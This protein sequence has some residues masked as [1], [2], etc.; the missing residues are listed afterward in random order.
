MS[1]APTR[2][3]AP[4]RPRR[5]SA[6]PAWLI[7]A[8]LL[9]VFL[10]LTFLL[11]VFPLKDVDF[12]WHLKTGDLIRQTG[13]IP[14]QDIYTY[15]VADHAW[16]DL[17]WGFQVLLSWGYQHAGVVGLNLAKCAINCAAI[18]LLLSARRRDWP[19]GAMLVAWLPALVLLG[20]RM[21][22]RPETLTLLYLAAFLAVLERWDRSAR[23]AF[24][25]PVVQVLWVNTQ[26]LFVLGPIVLSFALVDASLRPGAFG[27]ARRPWWRTVGTASTL[28][29][30]ACLVNPYGIVGALFPIQLAGTMADPIFREHIAELTPIPEF[31]R[32]TA[33]RGS[34]MLWLH[35]AVM[36]LGALSFLVPWVWRVWVRLAPSGPKH[37]GGRG[38]GPAPGK[39]KDKGKSRKASKDAARRKE[40]TWSPSPFRL[41]L[42]LAFSALS[43]QATRNSHQFAAVVGAV[44][45]WNVGEWAAVVRRRRA[46]RPEAEQA[47]V[48]RVW[49]L[50]AIVL[51]LAG[52]ASGGVYALAGE[53]RT[54]GLGEEPLWYP[55][56]AVR[57]AGKPGMPY[58]FLSF[59]DGHSAL[60]IYH[61]GPGHKVFGDPR[62]EVMGSEHFGRYIDLQRRI[63]S[64]RPG[65]QGDLAALGHPAV[66]VD[67]VHTEFSPIGAVMMAAPHWRCAWF[68]AMAA[69]FVH[70]E[71]T[72]TAVAPGVDFAAR[73]F[74]PEP[75]TDPRD[76]PMLMASAKALLNYAV[77]LQGQ[78][79][80]DL[81]RR[82]VPLGIDYARR[83]LRV[84]PGAAEG[85]KILGRLEATRD[86]GSP[87]GPRFR[88]PFDPIVDLA[89]ARATYAIRRALDR[90]PGDFMTL[91]SLI[92]LYGKRE[93]N[94]AALPLIDRLIDARPINPTQAQI[95]AGLMGLRGELRAQLG[96][97]PVAV[98]GNASEVEQGLAARLAA[99]RAASAAALLER[100]YP[101]RS[102]SWTQ[103]DL[104]A[105]LW[106]HLGEPE[107]ARAAW[108]EAAEPPR[109]ALRSARIAATFL[110]ENDFDAARRSYQEALAVE[111][112]MFEAHY[113]LAVLEHDAGRASA[114]LAA[115]RLAVAHAPTD[116]AR[117][118]AQ[119]LIATVAP[120]ADAPTPV[121]EAR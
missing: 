57:F 52:I 41:L 103:T 112:G 63:E 97:E 66:L 107:R 92:Q 22:V 88:K 83:A 53:G 14:H 109:P 91:F 104:L 42:F 115:A 121:P 61:H 8:A 90:A 105:T 54:I 40:E 64:D 29:V 94:E 13:R 28:T 80:D 33:G 37:D 79:R 38:G 46:P 47:I 72:S 93:M 3:P 62:L 36:A 67:N 20:G 34:F 95:Q 81:A 18:L 73:H 100:E 11:G 49:A 84:S 60:Y 87:L 43:L 5:S 89:S 39:G 75:A 2:A 110:I 82:L 10:A 120:F 118:A 96:P 69:V 6:A 85:W 24:V 30:L 23:L 21:Y 45:A 26:G 98:F 4:A 68:D 55:H 35:F 99:G 32:R 113:G 74:R 71:A 17:H 106:I 86:D 7:D 117:A 15:T 59:H 25:L 70:D 116:D 78:R 108:R 65:W 58:R 119:A 19:L 77:A 51:A 50:A 27:R 48:P 114:A 102:R 31:L 76:V 16:I 56:E 1:T 101:A 12:W 44:T 111:P 9:V